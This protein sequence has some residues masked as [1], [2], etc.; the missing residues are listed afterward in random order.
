MPL[1]LWVTLWGCK[2]RNLGIHWVVRSPR[3][4]LELSDGRLQRNVCRRN[5][6]F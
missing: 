5:R 2:L 6:Q 4:L 3:L 1:E